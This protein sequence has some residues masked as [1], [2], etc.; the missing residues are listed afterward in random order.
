M[1]KNRIYPAIAAIAILLTGSLLL[2]GAC[3]TPT[4]SPAPKKYTVFV[5]D[6]IEGGIIRALPNTGVKAGTTIT[7]EAAPDHGFYTF[8]SF[9]VVRTKNGSDVPLN[10][11]TGARRTFKMPAA[12]VNV[13]AV[14]NAV[15]V[16]G[17]KYEI[18]VETDLHNRAFKLESLELRELMIQA[19][20]GVEDEIEEES[21]A[22]V[23]FTGDS[24][25]DLI[26]D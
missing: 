7:I 5:D 23:P 24:T 20:V 15:A 6:D 2:L 16:P 18:F 1:K 22:V 26:L 21:M 13:S 14:F 4:S 9:T 25:Q 8:G 10:E 12:N 11:G 17:Q 3:E 19:G